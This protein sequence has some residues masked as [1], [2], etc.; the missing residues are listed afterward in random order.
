M[1]VAVVGSDLHIRIFDAAGIQVTDKRENELMHGP[2][3]DK[4]KKRLNSSPV[5]GQAGQAELSPPEKQEIM[6][7]A[8][9][10]ARHTGSLGGA[11][12][13]DF[14]SRGF[15]DLSLWR[16]E[17]GMG[18]DVGAVFAWVTRNMPKIEHGVYLLKQS[19]VKIS[20]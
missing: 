7:D 16:V 17:A 9:S 1:I 11:I 10:L 18:F 2:Q 14:G 3:L 12:Y 20:D 5:P 4:L 6:A 15:E 19:E 13:K 8:A